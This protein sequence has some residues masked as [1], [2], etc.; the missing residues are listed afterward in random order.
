MPTGGTSAVHSD[1][2]SPLSYRRA[3]RPQGQT[4]ALRQSGRFD[5]ALGELVPSPI[6]PRARARLRRLGR[7]FEVL[8]SAASVPHL[9]PK[10]S[11]KSRPSRSRWSKRRVAEGRCLGRSTRVSTKDDRTGAALGDGQGVA[12]SNPVSPTSVM[13]QDIGI[14]RTYVS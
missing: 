6:A 13:S 12:G 5:A 9:F 10:N 11:V 8:P 2:G 4:Q 1:G 3:V 14:A 7:R